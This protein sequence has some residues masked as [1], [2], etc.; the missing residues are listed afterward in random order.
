MYVAKRSTRNM[1]YVFDNN[2]AMPAAGSG[3]KAAA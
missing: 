3:G 1:V 2:S